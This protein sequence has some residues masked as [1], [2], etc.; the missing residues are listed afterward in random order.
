M[1]TALQ[2][3]GVRLIGWL[4]AAVMV[5]AGAVL[6][7]GTAYADDGVGSIAGTV[8]D[9]T[10]A[11][12]EGVEVVV[13]RYNVDWD[14]WEWQSSTV[15]GADGAYA[16]AE[17]PA[18]EYKV[19]FV[20]GAAAGLVAE[21]WDGAANEWSATPLTVESG[22]ALVDIN[23]ALARGGS[24]SGVVTDASGAPIENVS[25]RSYDAD[26]FEMVGWASTDATGAYALTGLPAGEYSVHFE[27][28]STNH[29][30]EWWDD[31]PRSD[32][33]TRVAVT[34]G[35]D[36]TGI[37]A[38]LAIGN[39]VSGVVSDEDG[40]PVSGVVVEVVS[41]TG[42]HLGQG[43]TDDAGAYTAPSI[44]D[45]AYRVHFN[46]QYASANLVSEWWDD[47]ALE[48]DAR[49]LELAG[50]AELESIDAQLAPAGAISGTVSDP[51]GAPVTD[52]AVTLYAADPAVEGGS[53]VASEWVAA[54]GSFAFHGVRAGS[55]KLEV[56]SGS[57]DVLGEW[58]RDASSE[59]A[60]E[61]VTVEAGSTA[62]G[63]DVELDAAGIVTGVVSDA[64]GA[65]VEGV[66]V[67]VHS[68]VSGTISAATD[69]AGIYRIGGLRTGSAK[70]RF[71][72]ETASSDVAGEWWND[73]LSADDATPIEITQGEIVSGIDAQLRPGGRITG[74]VLGSDGA[75][76]SSGMVLAYR[77]DEQTPASQTWINEDGSFAVRGLAP[78][79]YRVLVTIYAEN[80]QIWEWWDNAQT[81]ESA[82]AVQIAEGQAVDGLHMTLSEDDGSVVE[83]YDASL[84]GRV[85][86]EHGQQI[87]GA[88]VGIER[89]NA[90]SG[91]EAVMGDDGTWSAEWMAAGDY[92]VFATATIDGQKITQ[93]WD[94]A[95][96]KESSDIITL[97]RSEQ[98]AGI[99][100][101][102]RR[103]AP[104]EMESSTPQIAGPPR[105]G[106][107]LSVDTGAWTEGATFAY[108]WFVGGEP[109]DG[110]TS[111]TYVPTADQVRQR[112]TVAVTGSLDGYTSVT[113]LSEPSAPILR[114]KHKPASG[115]PT[116]GTP[117]RGP[118]SE[119]TG[120]AAL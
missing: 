88:Y 20:P 113:Q 106:S 120:R 73:A 94:G 63:I 16:L 43:W 33:A 66:T 67:E 6:A 3:S 48:A 110:A 10:G 34:A 49:V 42:E 55:Y 86:D 8:T 79:T 103:P 90:E 77:G 32:E 18:G 114:E 95:S 44:P 92:R 82:D 118:A 25:V 5:I 112:I 108:Q 29:I 19:Q 23:P 96:D 101:V 105:V 72:T 57:P 64:D 62:S 46:A 91:F 15:T 93:W 117:S 97:A 58:W 75:P 13:H 85:V 21:W 45:G 115:K 24:V 116:A 99:D 54:D 71:L 28:W 80:L 65:P 76:L 22:A 26:S 59:S 14:Y 27:A 69:G 31:A 12:A 11:T 81:R 47:V 119:Q 1:P 83:S 35:E 53:W 30:T 39:S 17:L 56:T 40:L 74:T 100:F 7:P 68:E 107:V 102:L 78:G 36:T 104:P 50:G 89:A 41:E 38:E 98:R 109:I 111:P 60:A 52:A 37:S 70:I 4:I 87:P 2:R 9:D 84:S 61:A 51:S